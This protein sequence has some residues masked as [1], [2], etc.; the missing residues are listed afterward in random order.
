[1]A[2]WSVL[3]VE[4]IKAR[5][6]SLPHSKLCFL[7]THLRHISQRM[8]QL[9]FFFIHM[10]FLILKLLPTPN[11]LR[12]WFTEVLCRHTLAL[13]AF[14]SSSLIFPV[15]VS[16]PWTSKIFI[17]PCPIIRLNR[18]VYFKPMCNGLALH[19]FIFL[20]KFYTMWF[21]FNT[22]KVAVIPKQFWFTNLPMPREPWAIP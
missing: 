1:M 4:A 6:N 15:L 10:S 11:Y 5:S 14:L 9:H 22:V 8:F 2:S 20:W 19:H 17:A 12:A 3:N 7:C 16:K 18:G 13:W 21:I